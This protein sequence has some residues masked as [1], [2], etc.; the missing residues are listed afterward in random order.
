MAGCSKSVDDVNHTGSPALVGYVIIYVF[1][2]PIERSWRD[3]GVSC[4]HLTPPLSLF[5]LT[6]NRSVASSSDAQLGYVLV[7]NG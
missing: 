4:T 3:I 1:H 7:D 6:H 5:N 2:P